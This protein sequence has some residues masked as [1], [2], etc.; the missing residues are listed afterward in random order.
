ME[1]PT[2][3]KS[4]VADMNAKEAVDHVAN[5]RSVER[6]Q[7]IVAV[8]TRTSV[9]EAAAKRLGELNA[10]EAA[11]AETDAAGTSGKTPDEAAELKSTIAK[12]KW[13]GEYPLKSVPGNKARDIINALDDADA[14][15]VIIHED[16]RASVVE[17]AKNRLRVTANDRKRQQARESFGIYHVEYGGLAG[18]FRAR[19]EAEAWAMFNDA[20]KT[21]HG[22]KVPGR[23]VRK[24]RSLP[25]EESAMIPV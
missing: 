17:A 6:L 19:S 21:S 23:I 16:R 7:K 8:D 11:E 2:Q 13:D 4:P 10:P 1:T 18:D 12:L 20:N 15:E 22:P 9:V 14:L 5:M 24:V 3:E 25:P